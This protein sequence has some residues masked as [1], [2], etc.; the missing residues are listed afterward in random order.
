MQS[1]PSTRSSKTS[2]CNFI[3]AES[4]FDVLFCGVCFL[5]FLGGSIELI[6]FAGGVREYVCGSMYMMAV[7]CL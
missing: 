2:G 4:F 7:F 1:N 5:N 3:N 6:Y